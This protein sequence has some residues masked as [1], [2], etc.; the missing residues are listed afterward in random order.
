MNY[1]GKI[2]DVT[3][4]SI[5]DNNENSLF[6]PLSLKRNIYLD[7]KKNNIFHDHVFALLNS[8]E[9]TIENKYISSLKPTEFSGINNLLYLSKI[10]VINIKYM[11]AGCEL[12]LS[13]P[14]LSKWNTK[15]VIN[16]EYMLN[17]L[18]KIVNQRDIIKIKKLEI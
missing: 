17:Y 18:R 13:L 14:D 12:L 2:C 4:G 6:L 16:M 5:T 11:F 1:L 8:S 9:S 10:I 7:N 15:N 3:D